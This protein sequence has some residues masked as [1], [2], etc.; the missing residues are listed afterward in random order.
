MTRLEETSF[1]TV[2]WK[3]DDGIRKTSFKTVTG[4]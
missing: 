3:I 4:K 2:I 1:K